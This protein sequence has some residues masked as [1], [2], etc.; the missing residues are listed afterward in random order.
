MKG[1]KVNQLVEIHAGDSF[2]VN[3]LNSEGDVV[4]R[5]WCKPK[6]VVWDFENFFQT[7]TAEWSEVEP[8]ELVDLIKERLKEDGAE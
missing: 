8:K 7:V 2:M 3:V 5:S 6:G 4:F 1:K